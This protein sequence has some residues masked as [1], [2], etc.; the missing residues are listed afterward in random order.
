MVRFLANHIFRI[1]DLSQNLDLSI[2][3]NS[4][5]A[6]VNRIL[7]HHVQW[8]LHFKTTYSARKI[9]SYIE[10]GLKVE[11]HLYGIYKSCVIDGRS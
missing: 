11:G 2:F 7:L 4:S 10:G 1:T 8:T 9:W 3:E 5:P 6:H